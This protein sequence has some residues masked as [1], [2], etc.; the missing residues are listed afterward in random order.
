MFAICTLKTYPRCL[1]ICFYLL[2]RLSTFPAGIDI[3][4]GIYAFPGQYAVTG[5]T[6]NKRNSPSGTSLW[7]SLDP[8]SVAPRLLG[9]DRQ[10]RSSI[11]AGWINSW[12]SGPSG[13]LGHVHR[14]RNHTPLIEGVRKANNKLVYFIFRRWLR[15]VLT[16]PLLPPINFEAI[17]VT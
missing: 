1:H 9:V 4:T 13:K 15:K 8:W 7:K 2:L 3:V 5:S 16:S 11:I 10:A 6:C 17:K 12:F 14:D